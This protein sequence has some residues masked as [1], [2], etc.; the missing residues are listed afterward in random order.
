MITKTVYFKAR[1]NFS[2][3][4]HGSNPLLSGYLPRRGGANIRIIVKSFLQEYFLARK[5]AKKYSKDIEI[6]HPVL[7]GCRSQHRLPGRLIVLRACQA[8]VEERRRKAIENRTKWGALANR[9]PLQALE[10]PGRSECPG[11]VAER[12]GL[13]RDLCQNDWLGLASFLGRSTADPR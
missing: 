10:K 7:L 5:R 1:F 12:T 9:A 6:D 8:V 4:A 11:A 3:P 2:L 13:N